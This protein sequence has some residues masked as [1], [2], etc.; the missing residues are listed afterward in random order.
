LQLKAADE[1]KLL[2]DEVSYLQR[3]NLVLKE[4][5]L[6]V[7]SMKMQSGLDAKMPQLLIAAIIVAVLGIAIGKLFL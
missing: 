5:I 1:L 4:D 3:E 7:K 2:R 6:K